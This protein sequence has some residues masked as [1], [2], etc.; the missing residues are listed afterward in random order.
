MLRPEQ[1]QPITAIKQR[2]VGPEAPVPLDKP[3]GFFWAQGRLAR[4][5]RQA[6]LARQ[7]RQ[8][9]GAAAHQPALDHQG[10][11]PVTGAAGLLFD[12]ITLA[13][14]QGFIETGQAQGPA[15]APVAE[16][17]HQQGRVM[18]S[19]RHPV[20][21]KGIARHRLGALLPRKVEIINRSHRQPQAQGPGQ[22]YQLLTKQTFAGPHRSIEGKP[23]PLSL[24]DPPCQLLQHRPGKLPL[25]QGVHRRQGR[26]PHQE[27]I[28]NASSTTE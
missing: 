28:L 21:P 10:I 17:L 3:A 20:H 26:G 11:H 5:Q 27:P 16:A 18:A 23:W 19:G 25:K 6:S 12:P 7:T 2:A 15:C 4:S 13:A 9:Q 1:P 22:G 14:A 24:G 8:V